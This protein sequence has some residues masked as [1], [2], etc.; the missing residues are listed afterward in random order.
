MRRQRRG[1][2][3]FDTLTMAYARPA[4]PCRAFAILSLSKD[5][6]ADA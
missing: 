6:Q 1:V 5:G 3:W 4:C 2:A